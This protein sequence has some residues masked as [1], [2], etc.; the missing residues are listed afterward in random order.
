MHLS[1]PKTLSSKPWLLVVLLF[2]GFVA[3]WI[4]FI[5]LAIKHAPRTIPVATEHAGH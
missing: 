2:S 3:C 5:T 1:M 4:F